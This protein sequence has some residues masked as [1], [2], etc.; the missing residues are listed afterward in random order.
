MTDAPIRL[1]PHWLAWAGGFITHYV[2]IWAGLRMV[3]FPETV[4]PAWPATG[5]AIAAL[6]MLGLR[7]WPVIAITAFVAEVPGRGYPWLDWR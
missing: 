3:V 4:S 7:A 6:A 2:A 5:V 1:Y